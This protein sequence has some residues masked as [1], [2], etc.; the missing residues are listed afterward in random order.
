MGIA[1]L[2]AWIAYIAAASRG[3][4]FGQDDYRHLTIARA[5]FERP[6]LILG[7]WARPL[8]TLAYM[9]A[10]AL[11]DSAVRATSVALLFA[12]AAVCWRLA[13]A[14]ELRLVPAAALFL[15]AQ[16]AA[17]VLGVAALPGTLFAFILA[18][19]LLLRLRRH[20][21]AA[22]IVASL[23]PLAR[24][25][26]IAVLAIW[27]AV[28]TWERRARLVPVLAAGLVAWM[29]IGGLVFHD[30][31]HLWHDNY[32]GLLGSRYGR[33]GSLYAFAAWPQAFGPVVGGLAISALAWARRADRLVLATAGGLTTFFWVTWALP[34]FQSFPTPYYFV[35]ISVPVAL[36]AHLALDRVLSQDR[37]SWQPGVVIALLL[38]LVTAVTLVV[39]PLRV[40]EH[41]TQGAGLVI[42]VVGIMAL[43]AS[44]HSMHRAVAAAALI[45]AVAAGLYYVR[46]VPLAG[47]PLYGRQLADYVAANSITVT[48][49]TTPAFTWYTRQ[50]GDDPGPGFAAWAHVAPPGT[51]IVWDHDWGSG[52]VAEPALMAGGWREVWVRQDRSGA[53]VV[54]LRRS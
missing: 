5:A 29:A 12:T 45:L 43:A 46:P 21:L 41:A 47:E 28:L 26:G 25:E 37:E 42:V 49:S 8:M 51:Y 15:V 36:L 40:G 17:M 44:R 50:G 54:L 18:V 24:L 52:A 27:A 9:P 48:L 7:V 6:Q 14:L 31:L 39:R 1:T 11:G 19:A 30:P 2:A 38:A 3:F 23:L 35:S 16:P 4:P 10:S 34:A 32:Y 53:K 22:A 33:T 13:A 20:Q